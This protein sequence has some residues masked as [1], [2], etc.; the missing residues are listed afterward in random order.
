[1]A[2][3]SFDCMGANIRYSRAGKSGGKP[4]LYLRSEESLPA[5]AD[6]V[7]QLRGDYDV[8]APD[9]PGFG[10]SDNPGWLRGMGDTAYFYLDFLEHLGLQHIHIVGASMGGWIGAEIA[11]R[12][13]SRIAS[14][15]L[16]APY[17]A[18]TKG[19]VYGDVFLWTPE[20]NIR[21][22]FHDQTFA[23][24][25]LGV[26]QTARETT[27]LLKDRYAT[28]RLGWQ[29]RFHNPEMQRW[30]HR[31]KRPVLLVW[32][33]DDKVAPMTMSKAWADGLP[34]SNLVTIPACGHL[35][36]MERAAHTHAAV[37]S[38]IEETRA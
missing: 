6:F 2:E 24:K 36:H 27:G 28:A 20:Q 25:F 38:F 19:E 32:G 26:D 30:L 22:R 34:T 12:D 14:L 35:P 11:V 13:C 15:S 37:A 3:G 31:I 5:D 17:G 29:P 9:H 16:I 23:E 7:E 33:E 8:I 4:V 1:M 10:Q 18:R 21:N